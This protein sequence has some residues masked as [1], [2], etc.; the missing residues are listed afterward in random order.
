MYNHIA[1]NGFLKEFEPDGILAM[2]MTHFTPGRKFRAIHFDTLKLK[3][4]RNYG[5][6]TKCGIS[7]ELEFFSDKQEGTGCVFVLAQSC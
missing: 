4:G 7:H 2:P 1:G 5:I 3:V 6:R